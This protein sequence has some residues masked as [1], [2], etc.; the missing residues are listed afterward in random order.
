MS[1]HLTAFRLA[2]DATLSH[3]AVTTVTNPFTLL[4]T[5]PLN[6]EP[7]EKLELWKKIVASH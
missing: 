2:I 1:D 7:L 4:L 6:K 5:I 3:R